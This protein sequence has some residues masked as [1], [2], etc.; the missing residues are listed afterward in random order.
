MER[1]LPRVMRRI[2]LPPDSPYAGW[3]AEMR[4]NPP[5]RVITALMERGEAELLA[6]LIVE[7]N[8]V[9]GA[10]S[11]LPVT[12]ETVAQELPPDLFKALYRAYLKE[13]WNPFWLASASG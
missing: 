9:D 3:W 10:G 1:K 11:E 13:V 5:M 8:F 12:P 7:W 2:E 6:D 4:T